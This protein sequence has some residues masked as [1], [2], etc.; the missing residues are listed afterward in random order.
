MNV[1]RHNRFGNRFSKLYFRLSTG[2]RVSDT[3]TGLRGIPAALLP[4]AIATEGNRY[5]YE[6]NFLSAAVKTVPVKEIAVATIYERNAKSHFNPIVDSLRI[7]RTLFSYPIVALA[8]WAIDLT[9]FA[10]FASLIDSGVVYQVLLATVG[11]RL[12][13]GTFNFAVNNLWVFP[14]KG[15][16]WRKA[17][18]YAA[19]FFINMALS[20]ALVYAFSFLSSE[21]VLVKFVVDGCIFIANYFIELTWVFA[22]GRHRER[23]SHGKGKRR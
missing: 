10:L 16:F 1:P 2:V 22:S 14:S 12:I 9:L 6:M 8:S 4:L 5:D 15:H 18:R 11:A 20:F 3:Q 21:L 7:Y 13:S 19:I 23:V 17:A